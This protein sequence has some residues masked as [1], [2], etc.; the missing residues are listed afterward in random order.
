ML[1]YIYYTTAAAVAA[2]AA[3]SAAAAAAAAVFVATAAAYRSTDNINRV[4]VI[5]DHY[6]NQLGVIDYYIILN[7]SCFA[8][9]L[10]Q[11]SVFRI[12]L[13]DVFKRK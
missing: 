10:R 2:V 11:N 7:E 1:L 8:Q 4:G 6:G 12:V 3:V 13:N 5:I 9:D